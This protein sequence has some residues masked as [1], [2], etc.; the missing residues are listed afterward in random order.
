[1][2]LRPKGFR[3]QARGPRFCGNCHWGGAGYPVDKPEWTDC[4]V[5]DETYDVEWR[6]VCPQWEPRGSRP[7]PAWLVEDKP[8]L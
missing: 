5:M 7:G 6:G 2:R 8:K 1:M 4:C 3:T